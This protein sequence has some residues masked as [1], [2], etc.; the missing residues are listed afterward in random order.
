MRRYSGRRSSSGRYVSR[1]SARGYSFGRNSMKRNLIFICI[2]AVL[3]IAVVGVMLAYFAKVNR[4]REAQQLAYRQEGIAYYEQGDYEKALECFDN[5]LG[6]SLGSIDDTEMD[7]CFYKARTQYELGDSEGALQTYHA[8]IEYNE[9]PKA[10]FLRGNLYY[11]MGEEAKALADYDKAVENETADYDLYIAIYEILASKDKVEKGQE[12][13]NKA[14]ELKGDK[15]ADKVKKGRIHFLL[16]EHEKAVTLL[17]EAAKA[18]AEG[19]YY[20]FLVY[21]SLEN[22]EK[23]LENLN[24]YMEKETNLDSYKLY[25]MGTSLL[26]KSMYE[27]AAECYNK[28]L[29]LEKVPN[30]QEIMKNLVVTYEKSKNFTSAKEVMKQY[31]EEYPEDEEALREYTFLETR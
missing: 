19:Y 1:Y 15:A 17:E 13:L 24:T 8:V 18:E 21:D 28:A 2:V 14:L 7:I 12:I 22:S 29:E 11:S 9:S 5:A 16:E 30:K 20:L 31:I 27:S 3:I 23:A 4:E 25:E 26:N 6:D 10:Y